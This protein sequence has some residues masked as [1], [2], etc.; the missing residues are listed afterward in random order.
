[1]LRGVAL[2][3]VV[4]ASGALPPRADAQSFPTGTIVEDV[5]CAADAAQSY[6]LYLPSRYAPD[7]P[8]SLLIAFHPGARGRAMVERYQG[9]AEQYGYIVAASNN[10]RNGP[11]SVSV[12]AV[13]AMTA[14]VAQRFAIN[15]QRV[16]ATGMSGGARVAMQLALAN[17]TIAG[18]IASS[19]GFPDSEPRARVGFALFATAGRDDFNY[20]EMRLLDRK[21]KT[22]HRL[23][24]FEGGHTLP[25][26][27]VALDAIEWMELQAMQA[28]RRGRDE[29]L[30][31]RLLERRRAASAAASSP[32]GVVHALEAIVAD[33]SGLRDVSADGRRLKELSQQPDVKKAL[34]REI[35]ADD[36][37]MQLL[38]EIFGL[39]GGLG[40][41][42]RHGE[43]M[44]TLRS[45]L[46]RLAKAAA[47]EGES[48]ER[49]QARRV[50]RT[51][52]AGAS[53]RVQD[54]AYLQ[55]LNELAPRR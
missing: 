11:W 9:A 16:Y 54:P 46:S 20:I 5:K 3:L 44:M 52:T 18:V 15:P 14:D 49:S 37:E 48:A 12:A 42:D 2:L 38:S 7:R 43:A 55:L 31:D 32:A 4:A 23:V 47:A 1:M 33:F 19:A 39:E 53:G 29:A 26:E 34:A 22:P 30:I 51:I 6:A 28:G 21:L 13:N 50:L 41:P 36:A 25:P 17:E 24:I 8:W 45:R 40:D 35:K 10:S 27:S